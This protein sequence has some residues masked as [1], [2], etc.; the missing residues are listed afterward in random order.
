MDLHQ[1]C[2]NAI[3]IQ[4][5]CLLIKLED[6]YDWTVVPTWLYTLLTMDETHAWG[7]RRECTGRERPLGEFVTRW[8]NMA[9]LSIKDIPKRE[10]DD[11]PDQWGSTSDSGSSTG[12]IE[13]IFPLEYENEDNN[14]D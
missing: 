1:G 2:I 11:P 8:H 10:L 12:I 3:V 7:L 4:C 6:N 14:S 13:E 9:D 5:F